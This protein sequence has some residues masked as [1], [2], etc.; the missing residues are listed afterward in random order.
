MNSD[1][2]ADKLQVMVCASLSIL[3][4]IN[5]SHELISKSPTPANDSPN[6]TQNLLK[7]NQALSPFMA[8]HYNK[9]KTVW[10]MLTGLKKKLLGQINEVNQ[11]DSW[12]TEILNLSCLIFR[13]RFLFYCCHLNVK[14]DSTVFNTKCLSN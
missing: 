7:S 4:G 14:T 9:C 12:S 6:L 11:S 1:E 13:A 10:S 5:T 3:S 8:Q 2:L